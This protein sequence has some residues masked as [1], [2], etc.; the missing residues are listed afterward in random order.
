MH[1]SPIDMHGALKFACE[2]LVYFYLSKYK[3]EY[4][5]ARVFNIFGGKGDAFSMIFRIIDAYL[6]Q[7]KIRVFNKGHALRDYIH[8]DDVVSSYQR[9]LTL[10][11]IP[12]INIAS[13][14]GTSVNT[15]LTAL[16]RKGILFDTEYVNYVN[17]I[18]V[19]VASVKLAEKYLGQFY[20]TSVFSYLEQQLLA[21][22][23]LLENI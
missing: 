12:I 13:G 21:K 22:H 20:T 18:S 5:I 7:K 4:T 23:N 6:S 9:L 15:L 3:I 2:Q 16:Q 1:A 10:N 11:G 19:S 14:Q 17:E 8:V